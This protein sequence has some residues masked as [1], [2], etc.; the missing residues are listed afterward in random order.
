MGRTH[1][2]GRGGTH[3]DTPSYRDPGPAWIFGTASKPGPLSF[4][5][6][7]V[8]TAIVLEHH[9]DVIKTDDHM[10]DRGP[11]GGYAGGEVVVPRTPEKSPPV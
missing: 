9:L 3:A 10:I 2:A 1:S 5:D 7:A 11:E 8:H 4:S 6:G